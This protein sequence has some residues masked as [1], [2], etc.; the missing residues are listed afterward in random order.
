MVSAVIR[1]FDQVLLDRLA[2][3]EAN[4]TEHYCDEKAEWTVRHGYTVLAARDKDLPAACAKIKAQSGFV[5]MQVGPVDHG[6]GRWTF[7]Q[8]D[9]AFALCAAGWTSED[10]GLAIGKG[11]SRGA[12]IGRLARF[13]QK[14]WSP[15]TEVIRGKWTQ[16]QTEHVIALR[17]SGKTWLQVE[18]EMGVPEVTAR[19]NYTRA[20]M[21]E[22]EPY[23]ARV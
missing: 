19:Y 2:V 7:A 3:F 10:T 16:A 18:Q 15:Y 23:N 22:R 5:E 6:H 14:E 21:S 9:M 1:S 20:T 4:L 17:N 13:D 12:V 8:H 11:E